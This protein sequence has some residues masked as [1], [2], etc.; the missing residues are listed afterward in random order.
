MFVCFLYVWAD[1][2][3]VAE[4]CEFKLLS[5]AKDLCAMPVCFLYVRADMCDE[6]AEMCEFELLSRAKDLCV[7]CLCVSCTYGQKC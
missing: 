4:M 5:R 1:M 3:E 7:Q 2:C 6:V